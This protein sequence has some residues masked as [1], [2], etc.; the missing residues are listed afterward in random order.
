MTKKIYMVFKRR[1]I[2][3][4]SNRKKKLYNRKLCLFIV[5]SVKFFSSCKDCGTMVDL[6]FD[7]VKGT[8]LFNL[9]NIPYR[10]PI[11]T[12][13]NELLKC[14][15]RCIACHRNRHKNEIDYK[16]SINPITKQNIVIMNIEKEISDKR[17]ELKK[18]KTIKEK[19]KIQLKG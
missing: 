8:K 11:K 18:Q 14:E 1:L 17:K 10:T 16:K 3:F 5:K 7:H 12:V 9:S 4:I 19:L 15:I 13:I 2:L 6:S